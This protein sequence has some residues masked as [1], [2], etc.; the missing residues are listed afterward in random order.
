MVRGRME[1]TRRTGG[2]DLPGRGARQPVLPDERG[3]PA[4]NAALPVAMPP[5][6]IRPRMALE[7][8]L[9]DVEA[10][11]R[12]HLELREVLSASTVVIP[13]PPDRDGDDLSLP[14]L[15]IGGRQAVPLFSSYERMRESGGPEEGAEVAFD[16]LSAGWPEGLDAVLDPGAPWALLVPAEAMAE[17]AE[18]SRV[19][20]GTEV[21]LRPVDPEFVPDALIPSVHAALAGVPQVET[22]WAVQMHHD[23]DLPGQERLVLAFAG[24]DIDEAALHQTLG[25]VVGPFTRDIAIQSTVL[26]PQE[27]DWLPTTIRS[28]DPFYRR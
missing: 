12:T 25:P 9:R 10:G 2:P 11:T 14:V 6:T 8:I 17:P 7:Q 3:L 5:T 24:V 26:L 16:A 21:E 23:G 13:G 18:Q 19:T 28:F 20:A 22:A 15:E 27:D 4:S 1:T